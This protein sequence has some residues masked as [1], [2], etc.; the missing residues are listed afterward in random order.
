MINKI[1]KIIGKSISWRFS[2]TI[3]SIVTITLSLY[4]V[5]F[6]INNFLKM[7]NE[8]NNRAD[9]NLKLAVVSLSEPVWNCDTKTVE[10]LVDSFFLD[11][12]VVY[13]HVI[14]DEE[15]FCLKHIT[16]FQEKKYDYYKNSMMYIVRGSSIKMQDNVIG[17]IEI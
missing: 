12:N 10:N 11:K 2:I 7:N 8:L 9:H 14:A 4:G 1:K 15:S 3:I 6:T 16:K 17:S 13:I 5:G